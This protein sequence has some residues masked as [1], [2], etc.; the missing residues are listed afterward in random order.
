MRFDVRDVSSPGCKEKAVHE[1]DRDDGC[2]RPSAGR[3]R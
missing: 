3:K 2:S 1:K